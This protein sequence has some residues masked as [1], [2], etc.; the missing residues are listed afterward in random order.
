MRRNIEDACSNNKNIE[1][2]KRLLKR[3]QKIL[4]IH[5]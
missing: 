5:F 3:M 1:T 2:K 4:V